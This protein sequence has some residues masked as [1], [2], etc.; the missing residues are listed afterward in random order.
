MSNKSIFYRN[1]ILSFVLSLFLIISCEKEEES[2]NNNHNSIQTGNNVLLIVADDI[3]LDATI[4]YDVGSQKPYLPTLQR[5]INSGVKFNN[6]W[7]NPLCTPT[8]GTILTG[9]YGY[10]TGVLDV[11]DLLSVSE[12]SIFKYLND[13]TNYSSAYI[14]KWH[15][16]GKPL[17]QN[18]PNNIGID[19][20]AGILGGG[21]TDYFSWTFS[22]NGQNSNVSQYIT[23]KLTD[24]AIGWINNQNNP[25]FLYLAYNAP[26]A[27][28]HLAPNHLHSQGQLPGDETSIDRNPLPYYFSMIEAMDAEIGRLIQSL[29]EDIIRNTTIIFVGDNGTPSEV[30]QQYNPKR[31]KGSLYK[32]GINVPMIVSGNQVTRLNDTDNSLINTT[33]LFSTV[34]ELCGI[35]NSNIYDS[36]SFIKLLNSS[37]FNTSREY[38][39]SE[40]G[41]NNYAIRNSTH[42]YIHL[43]D[44]SESLFNLSVNEFEKPNLLSQNQLPLSS[45][46]NQNKIELINKLNEIR[47]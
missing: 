23:T 7:S 38:I 13:N 44:G 33:D 9:K 47:N 18:H 32:G 3:G 14:G 10:R 2:K 19:Y 39:Y 27:P 8:R 25:W 22:K 5:L 28:F 34:A 17:N 46:D 29:G 37:S 41:N 4:G 36:K 1:K 31:V 30:S 43:E 24:E 12:V 15:L 6:V 16:S 45:N 20:F 42:K 26:H 21:V 11:D 40:L 35:R